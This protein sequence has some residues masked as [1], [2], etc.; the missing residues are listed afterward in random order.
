[1]NF[2]FAGE[3]FCGHWLQKNVNVLKTTELYT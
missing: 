2:S 3:K 1:M